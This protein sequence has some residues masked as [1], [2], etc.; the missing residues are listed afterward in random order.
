[1]T[2]DDAVLRLAGFL[3]A[4]EARQL[5]DRLT[6][7]ATMRQALVVVG[8]ARRR[9]AQALISAVDDGSPA[10]SERAASERTL[11]V[12]RAIEG[13][14]ARHTSVDPVWT[15]PKNLV[16]AGQLTASVHHFVSQARASVVCSTFNFQR[17][18]TLWAALSEV[19]RRPEVD[20]RVYVD[21]SAADRGSRPTTPTTRQVADELT[22]ATVLRTVAV[23]GHVVRNHAKFIAVDHH[24]LLVTS[25]N[26]SRS[27]EEFNVEL[28]LVLE[29]P[30]VT[31][32]VERQMQEL[33]A[34]VYEVV[35]R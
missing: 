3:T 14:L 32:A 4:T 27:A 13:A 26:F 24:Y 16:G 8:S 30:L 22:G 20:V 18:S 21:T 19:A 2:G 31:Q 6:A 28:G 10:R 15:A 9:E 12:L 17:S 25:A 35:R 34:L 23:D 11:T 29:N 1:M 7:G 5:A 33:E